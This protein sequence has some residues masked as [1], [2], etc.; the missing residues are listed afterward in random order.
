MK[1]ALTRISSGC[2]TLHRG[3]GNQRRFRHGKMKMQRGALVSC[4]R[5]CFFG[6]PF[7]A[8]QQ[9]TP[10]SA[11]PSRRGTANAGR[12]FAPRILRPSP[13]TP[14]EPPTHRSRTQANR[15]VP[16]RNRKPPSA[17]NSITPTACSP[18]SCTISRLLSMKNI[19]VNSRERPAG[20]A[21]I[22]F[23]RIL[24]GA[25]QKRGRPQEFPK[26]PR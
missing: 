24:S 4:Q 6:G 25:K 10:G 14:V 5:R 15:K 3:G 20:R 7:A 8:G 13:S 2:S 11:G 19:S 21:L 26:R 17:G 18:E 12:A 16:S 22:F 9:K 1:R 23:W